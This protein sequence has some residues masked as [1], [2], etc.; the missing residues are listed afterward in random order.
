MGV[1][2]LP[3][4]LSTATLT[5]I[6]LGL[7]L[8]TL[9]FGLWPLWYVPPNH[10]EIIEN[11]SAIRFRR[12]SDQSKLDAGGLAYTPQLLTFRNSQ[13]TNSGSLTIEIFAQPSPQFKWGLGLLT[14]LCDQ[15]GNIKLLLAQWKTHLVIRTFFFPSKKGNYTEIGLKDVL[16]HGQTSFITITSNDS[17]TV[18][19]VNGQMSRE[20]A[21]IRLVPAG[22][23]LSGY[24]L[25]FG[26]DPG[27]AHPWSGKLFGFALYDRALSTA[28]AA[29]RY[30]QW[31]QGVPP[32][33]TDSN[34][35]IVCY[36]F[37]RG[38]SSGDG[39]T[40]GDAS[41]GRNPL[42]LPVAVPFKKPLLEH[43]PLRSNGAMDIIIN[44][45]GFIPL[46]FFFA[47]WFHQVACRKL[48]GSCVT[49]VLCGFLLSLS[50]EVIQAFMPTRASSLNDLLC[51]TFGA[52][53]G[54]L[55]YHYLAVYGGPPGKPALP[56]RMQPA[57][58]PSKTS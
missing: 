16:I 47:Q 29:A 55:L 46:G 13:G 32:A 50:I 18:L 30:R 56:A 12:N 9:L 5:L 2:F 23:E 7:L 11:A 53:L 49:A 28:E 34:R 37:D 45:L 40:V 8:G 42:L 6:C 51:N 31:A 41:G 58:A 57:R 48:F 25:Y 19:F 39:T 14:A 54:A 33:A 27:L 21:G 10:A 38:T 35:P 24:R 36:S 1:S 22:L 26:N 4:T 3:R 15:D 20:V 44:L 43:S 17:K 52:V